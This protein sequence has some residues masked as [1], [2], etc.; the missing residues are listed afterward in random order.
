[1]RENEQ[2]KQNEKVSL[3]VSFKFLTY[4]MIYL[5]FRKLSQRSYLIIYNLQSGFIFLLILPHPVADKVESTTLTLDVRGKTNKDVY[6]LED[7]PFKLH[8]LISLTFFKS[9]SLCSHI[10]H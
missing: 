10:Y 7:K 5:S 6:D 3:N 9:L 1:M 8:L 4:R 2:Q